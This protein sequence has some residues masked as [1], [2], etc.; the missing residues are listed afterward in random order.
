MKKTQK[1]PTKTVLLHLELV[2]SLKFITHASTDE[3]AINH[4]AFSGSN[5]LI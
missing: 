2:F 5:I 4:F 3:G 1:N